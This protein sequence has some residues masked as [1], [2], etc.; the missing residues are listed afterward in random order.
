[1]DTFEAFIPAEFT[2]SEVHAMEVC[3][4]VGAWMDT[5]TQFV[6]DVEKFAKESA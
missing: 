1:M 2:V 4:Y 3:A 5:R 6:T